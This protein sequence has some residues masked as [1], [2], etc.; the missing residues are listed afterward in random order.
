MRVKSPN[1]RA[2]PDVLSVSADADV[3]A[4]ASVKKTWRRQLDRV[5]RSQRV[6]VPTLST[7]TATASVLQKALGLQ[8]WFTGSSITVAVID[9]GIQNSVDFGNRIVGFY[10][11]TAAGAQS[12]RRRSTS[13]A[14]ARTSPA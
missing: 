10:D 4:S 1:S 5:G 8:N 11:F 14:T 7:D 6:S 3:S 2:I 12:R 9:S 13:T